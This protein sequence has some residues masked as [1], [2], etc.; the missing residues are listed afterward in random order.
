[1]AWYQEWFGEEYLD[2][3]AHRDSDEADR[4]V[5]F[6]ESQFITKPRAILD[7]ACGAGRHTAALRKRGHRALG[8]DL[9]KVLLA[10]GKGLPRVNGDM[11]CLPFP[12][13]TFDWVVN[14]FT[15][16]GYFESEEEN[17]QVLVEMRRVLSSDGRLMMDLF[18]RDYVLSR[19]V[20]KE[21]RVLRG[22]EVEIERWYDPEQER[23][24][25]RIRIHTSPETSRSFLE[26]VRAYRASE[27]IES[28][29][30]AGLETLST[31]GNF[32]G[33]PF[34]PESPRFILIAKRHE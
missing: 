9:S 15:S 26:S 2:L 34:G 28:A 16:F 20:A 27:V 30:E 22:Q 10:E 33:E 6:L 7:V 25:K 1:M 14:F 32:A 13:Q 8:L 31:M 19:L 17:R 24:N 23:I 3:Y 11:G 5:D 29:R 18:N 4:H 21:K 12:D